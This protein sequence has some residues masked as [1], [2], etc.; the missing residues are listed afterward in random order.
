MNQ[1]Q[2][3]QPDHKFF[4]PRFVADELHNDKHRQRRAAGGDQKESPFGDSSF[5]MLRGVFIINRHTA[6]KHCHTNENI[7]KN[8]R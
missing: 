1:K 6:A 7:Q 2:S 5:F 4:M 3:G 8:V